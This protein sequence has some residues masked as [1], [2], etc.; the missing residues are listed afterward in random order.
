[1]SKIIQIISPLLLFCLILWSCQTV[2][3]NSIS[4]LALGDSYTIGE[5]VA[6]DDRWPVQLSDSLA[7]RGFEVQSPR[8]IAKTGWTTGDLL[9]A[10]NE[11]DPKTNYDLVSLL[12]GVNN[13]Y[14][15]SDFSRFETE[16]E[17]LLKQAISFANGKAENVFVVSIP[18]YGVTPFGQEK[19]PPKIAKELHR[20]NE[21]AQMTSKKYEVSF[22]N[23]TPISENAIDDS[24]LTASDGLHPSGT[25]YQ[26]W[27]S[28]ML[29]SILPKIN[30]RY[31][32][33]K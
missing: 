10:I 31:A 28:K 15:G 33:D 24:T 5:S 29:P 6:E 32:V 18:D 3:N 22:I 23:I 1:M 19:N 26:Q 25:M 14:Q 9:D 7:N 27:V 4:Y 17:E 20:Y 21:M 8:I 12:I 13:Q 11:A 30:S 16:F 2:D